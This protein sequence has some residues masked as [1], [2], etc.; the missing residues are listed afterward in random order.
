MKNT[1]LASMNLSNEAKAEITANLKESYDDIANDRL[2][3][4]DDMLDD[5]AD[6]EIDEA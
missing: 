6:V 4:L 3:D 2:V 1:A 5:L